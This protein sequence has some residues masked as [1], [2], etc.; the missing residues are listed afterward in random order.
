MGYILIIV[1]ADMNRQNNSYKNFKRGR[2]GLVAEDF[3]VVVLDLAVLEVVF[4]G[5]GAGG[6]F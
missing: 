4:G 3:L 2:R 1:L 6:S 5:G